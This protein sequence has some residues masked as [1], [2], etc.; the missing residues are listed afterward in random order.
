[1][2]VRT[3]VRLT[4]DLRRSQL[5]EFGRRHFLAR[6]YEAISLDDVA[7]EAGVSKGLLYHYFATKRDF[8][9]ACLR[10]S[11]EELRRVTEPPPAP[12]H[13]QLRLG[14]DAYLRHVEENADAWQAVLRGSIG[15]DPEVS[16]IAD[17]FRETMFRRI[18]AALP[19]GQPSREVEL[20]VKGWIGLVEAISLEWASR[21]QP[22]RAQLVELLARELAHML[23]TWPDGATAGTAPR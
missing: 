4:P 8:Y 21:H 18:V 11:V 23:A 2:A 12:P 3:H 17:G 22:A 7:E 5:L 6:P 14:L 13:E 19:D 10:S 20:A 9:M 15:C 16:A 1:M